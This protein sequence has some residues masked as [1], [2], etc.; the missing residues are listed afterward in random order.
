M[1][2]VLPSELLR[3][4]REAVLSVAREHGADKVRVFGSVARGEDGPGSDVDLLV[5][6]ESGR[7]LFDLMD[8]EDQLRNLLGVSVDVVSEGGLKPRDERIRAE[9]VFL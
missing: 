6:F 8:L 9:A 3:Q 1:V 2:A 7:G 4:Q 5:R